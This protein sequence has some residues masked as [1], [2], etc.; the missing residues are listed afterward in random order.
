MLWSTPR[1]DKSWI[2]FYIK[3]GYGTTSHR[4]AGVDYFAYYTCTQTRRGERWR[5]IFPC[6]PPPRSPTASSSAALPSY[7]PPK[8]TEHL[9]GTGGVYFQ[10]TA[11]RCGCNGAERG[12]TPAGR[13]SRRSGRVG[14][15]L[16]ELRTPLSR[17]SPP[18]GEPVL[19]AANFARVQLKP[20]C[21]SAV[22]LWGEAKRVCYF[23]H[24]N[25]L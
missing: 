9:D 23:A 3:E 15:S 18:G 6:P 5:A 7:T 14:P 22:L 8:G 24:K 2:K 10:R 25:L 13:F 17:V 20:R 4:C 11:G 19:F 1:T 16:A 12:V 21:A